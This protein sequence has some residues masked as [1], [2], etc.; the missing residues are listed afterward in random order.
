MEKTLLHRAFDFYNSI[1]CNKTF[2]ITFGRKNDNLHYIIVAF[3]KKDFKH[4]FGMHYLKDLN[5]NKISA[6][7][8]YHM[9]QTGQLT[10]S[11]IEK[12]SFYHKAEERLLN[13]EYVFKI[14]KDGEIVLED[15]KGFIGIE[16]KYLMYVFDNGL[17]YHLFYQEAG[18]TFSPC[19]FFPRNNS[20]YILKHKKYTIISCEEIS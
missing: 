18:Q 2:K 16:A 3:L 11:D 7:S 13:Y 9:I 5:L 8:I 17:F 10:Q 19:S 12:S 14:L 6:K 1:L 15:D 4:L 20:D